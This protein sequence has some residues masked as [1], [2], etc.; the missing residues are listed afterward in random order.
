MKPVSRFALHSGILGAVLFITF[1]IGREYSLWPVPFV[2]LAV[3]PSFA[4]LTALLFRNVLKSAQ[5]S[6]Q[7]FVTAFMGSVTTK[8]LLT[9][10]F[11]GVY[12]YSNKEEKVEVALSTFVV[13]ISFTIL[14]VRSLNKLVLADSSKQP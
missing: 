3:I 12:I 14:L 7:R 6:P 1:L 13:Y 4:I 9:A 5:K 2:I 11:L 8:L 10:T